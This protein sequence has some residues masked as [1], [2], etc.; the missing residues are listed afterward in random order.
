MQLLIICHDHLPT[1]KIIT[2]SRRM[3]F[4]VVEL[5]HRD[6]GQCVTESIVLALQIPEQEW[7]K[8]W[9]ELNSAS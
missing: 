3:I 8:L 2:L 1:Y 7:C 5:S 6:F 4:T 9:C